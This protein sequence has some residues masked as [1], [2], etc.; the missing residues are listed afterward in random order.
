M[1]SNR[2]LFFL[3]KKSNEAMASISTF[4]SMFSK[5]HKNDMGE[6]KIQEMV[7]VRSY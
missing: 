3:H 4:V 6:S 5:G 2:S 1:D 7:D